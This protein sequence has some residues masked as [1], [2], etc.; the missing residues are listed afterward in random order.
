[1]MFQKYQRGAKPGSCAFTSLSFVGNF[2]YEIKKALYVAH[3]SLP[4]FTIG[5]ISFG[6]SFSPEQ[7]HFH[8]WLLA[9]SELTVAF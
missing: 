4:F 5:R 1:M 3:I 6:H 2:R 7:T 9:L 8:K